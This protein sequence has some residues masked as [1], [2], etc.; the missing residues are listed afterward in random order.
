MKKLLYLFFAL[1]TTMVFTQCIPSDE[2]V[3][4][5]VAFNSLGGSEVATLWVDADSKVVKPA[6]PTME[7]FEFYGWYKESDCINAWDF[8]K[9]VVSK[10]I[11]L[12]AR[13]LDQSISTLKY[14]FSGNVCTMIMTYG[15]EEDDEHIVFTYEAKGAFPAG[16]YSEQ[17]WRFGGEFYQT[18]L[19]FNSDGTGT[20]EVRFASDADGTD[21]EEWEEAAFTYTYTGTQATGGVFSIDMW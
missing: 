18:R 2:D 19:T 20:N 11:T 12:Y 15:D 4:Y 1:I 3:Q 5:S 10:D 17:G 8:D 14:S 9:D 6:D 7:N 13:W 21:A 16:I